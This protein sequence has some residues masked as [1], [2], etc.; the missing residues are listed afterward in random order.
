MPRRTDRS[1]A[2]DIRRAGP[3]DLDDLVALHRAFCDI[4]SHPF[5]AV[6]AMAAFAPLLDDDTHGVV[7]IVDSP[8]AYAVLTWGWSI[9]AGGPEAVLDEI[10]VAERGAGVG[11]LLV[12]HVLADAGR[13]GLAR[14]FLETETHNERVRRFYRRHGFD[15]DDSIWMA[16]DFVDLS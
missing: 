13:R 8:P 16:H 2:V 6:R 9:E 15:A 12:Q 4:D 1:A 10:F 7:W 11:S 5:D 14:I 3:S